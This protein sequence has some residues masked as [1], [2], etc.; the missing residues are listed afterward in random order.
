MSLLPIFSTPVYLNKIEVQEEWIQLAEQE[1]YKRNFVNNAWMGEDYYVLNKLPD[2]K[3]QIEKLVDDYTRN[4]IKISKSQ[5]F[6]FLNSW[7]NKHEKG[8][9]GQ[10]HNHVNSM[11]SGVYYLQDGEDMGNLNFCRIPYHQALFPNHFCINY[12]EQNYI[13]S[14]EITITTESGLLVLF[15]SHLLHRIDRN[16]TDKFRYSLAFNLFIK[17]EMGASQEMQLTL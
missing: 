8:D 6:Y 7:I 1:S 11:I 9:W 13:N 2:L 4:I 10:N 12:D 17:G 15:P 14:D 5:K 3:K 16:N